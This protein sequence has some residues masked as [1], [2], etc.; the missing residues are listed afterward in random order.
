MARKSVKSKKQGR[1]HRGGGQGSGY[2]PGASLVAGSQLGEQIHQRYDSC[3]TVDR[4]GQQA[5][6]STGGLPGM[7]GGRYSIDVASPTIAG[8]AE[9]VKTPCNSQSGG[10]GLVGASDMDVLSE[11]TARYT[12][13]PS[14]WVGATGAPVLLNQPLDQTAWSK[15]CTQTAGAFS[16]KKRKTRRSMKKRT[17]KKTMKSRS[18]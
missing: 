12:H 1:R 2:A 3:M 13:A 14:G 4:P 16:S 6:A 8:V 18:R 15:A 17:M 10:V 11:S 7:R 9:V 5:F